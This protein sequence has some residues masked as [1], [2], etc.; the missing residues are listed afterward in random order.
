MKNAHPCATVALTLLVSASSV[1]CQRAMFS[2]GIPRGHEGQ[3][4][5]VN[6]TLY[7]VTPYPNDLIAIDLRQ[8]EGPIKWRYELHPDPMAVGKACCAM[9]PMSRR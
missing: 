2:T 5:V 7:V 6:N 3:P 8:L 9:T 1:A 4:V